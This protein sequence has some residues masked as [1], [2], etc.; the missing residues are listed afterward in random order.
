MLLVRWLGV[1]KGLLCLLTI[2]FCIAVTL[3]SASWRACL[4][5]VDMH[6]H[7]AF[8]FDHVLH[9]KDDETGVNRSCCLIKV[10]TTCCS[11]PRL[12]PVPSSQSCDL[13]LIRVY[14]VCQDCKESQRVCLATRRVQ[15]CMIANRLGWV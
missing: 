12:K 5:I 3:A 1:T 7:G 8:C 14:T 13:S 11:S 15:L 10:F 4:Y 6:L 9:G 2:P